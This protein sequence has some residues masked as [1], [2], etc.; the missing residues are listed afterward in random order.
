METPRAPSQNLVE[1]RSPILPLL[2]P[3]AVVNYF[4]CFKELFN[5]KNL[6]IL[7]KKIPKDSGGGTRSLRIT[8]RYMEI[9]TEK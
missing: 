3:M 4:K 7:R 5:V 9:T 6:G 8:I 2:T 1:S